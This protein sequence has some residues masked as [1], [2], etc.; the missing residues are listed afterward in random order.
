MKPIQPKRPSLGQKYSPPGSSMGG[1]KNP[2]PGPGGGQ[3]KVKPV[4]PRGR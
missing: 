3:P 4:K 1:A 2:R